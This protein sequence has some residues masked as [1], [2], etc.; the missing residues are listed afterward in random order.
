M[1]ACEGVPVL[2]LVACQIAASLYEFF[3][4]A[5]FAFSLPHLVVT[6]YS[7]LSSFVFLFLSSFDLFFFFSISFPSTNSTHTLTQ[8][9]ECALSNTPRKPT[10]VRRARKGLGN[11][12][13]W[14]MERKRTKEGR[15]AVIRC[16]EDSDI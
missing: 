6:N 14:Q 16:E 3:I 8:T 7:L 12:F 15:K 5:R 2:L 10:T 11:F 4:D 9:A 1:R 13:W